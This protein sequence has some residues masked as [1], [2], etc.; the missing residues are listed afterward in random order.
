LNDEQRL[1]AETIRSS[2]EALLV[3]INDILDYSKIEA[4]RLMLYPGTF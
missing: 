3:I 2:G 1:F 4:E